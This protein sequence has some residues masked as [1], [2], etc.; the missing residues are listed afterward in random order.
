MVGFCQSRRH[1]FRPLGFIKKSS[2]YNL[3]DD[4]TADFEK[5][6]K[7]QRKEKNEKETLQNEAEIAIKLFKDNFMI[8][9]LGT[10]QAM[11]INIFG[12]MENKQ[13]IYAENKKTTPMY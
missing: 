12:K 10:F 1:L 13:E 11:V 4:N 3:A 8:L 5:E 7:K 9:H 6:T 2:L